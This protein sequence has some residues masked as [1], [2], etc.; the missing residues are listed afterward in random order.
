MGQD[1]KQG[2]GGLAMHAKE[3]AAAST[4]AGT[5][6]AAAATAA[7]RTSVQPRL[8]S[9]ACLVPWLSFNARLA[10]PMSFCRAGRGCTGHRRC[11]IKLVL[12]IETFLKD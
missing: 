7:P 4:A 11:L 5:A 10:T 12:P 3:A 2:E 8:A 1:V 6:T 9:P